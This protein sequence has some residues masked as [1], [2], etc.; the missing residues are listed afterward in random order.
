MTES[1]TSGTSTITFLSDFGL[2]DEFVGVVHSVLASLAPAARVV[3][4]THQIPPHDV[5]AGA[6][7]LQRAAPY[8]ASGVVLAVVDPGVGTD[9]RAVAIAVDRLDDCPPPRRGPVSLVGPDNGLLIPVAESLGAIRRAVVLANPRYHLVGVENT[10]AT[11]AGRDIFAPVAAHLANGVDLDCLGP[12][13]E[14]ATLV[15]FDRP[16]SPPRVE[17]NRLRARVTWIDVFGNAQLDVAPS[18]LAALGGV[19]AVGAVLAVEAGVPP[20]TRV[21][22]RVRAYAELADDQLGLVV[23]SSGF[24]ALSYNQ[25]SAASRLGLAVGDPVV[26]ALVEPRHRDPGAG[27]PGTGRDRR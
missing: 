9:R 4:L 19:N 23:D 10:G 8:L 15:R 3:D 2:A 25:A 5:R 13:L 18:D 14:P 24:L 12:R 21:A 16:A 26:L 6:R 20:G 17:G 1:P 11:F 7:A 22:L 27:W